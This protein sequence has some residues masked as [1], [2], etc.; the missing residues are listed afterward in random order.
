MRVPWRVKKIARWIRHFKNAILILLRSLRIK[1]DQWLY[2][3]IQVSPCYQLLDVLNQDSFVID[4]GLGNDADFSRA[5]ISKY[6]CVC[7]GFDP[8]ERHQAEIK[9]QMEPYGD[10][11]KL[12]KLAVGSKCGNI[13][14]YESQNNV[15]GSVFKD[16]INVKKDRITSYAVEVVTLDDIL[17]RIGAKEVDVL[18]MDVEGAEYNILEQTSQKTLSRFK[19]MIVEFHHDTVSRF[20]LK[21]TLQIIKR[22]SDL[23]YKCYTEDGRNYLFINKS[24]LKN[25]KA[26]G[27]SL[28]RIK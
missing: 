8:T 4:I 16:H 19:Q 28:G 24:L 3:V 5:L 1:Y 15:S 12:M 2:P 21:N 26:I 14:F 6:Q 11:F 27:C 23:G 22:I 18:K 9:T 20:G 10:R 7:Y 13:T 25:H 17:N